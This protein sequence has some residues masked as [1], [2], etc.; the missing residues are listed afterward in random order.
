MAGGDK[1]N[2]PEAATPEMVAA[3]SHL[4]MRVLALR[5]EQNIVHRLG[6]EQFH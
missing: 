5:F 2:G 1:C 3:Q 4:E 6:E